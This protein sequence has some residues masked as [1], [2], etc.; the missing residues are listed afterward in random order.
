MMNRLGQRI[1]ALLSSFYLSS[2]RR[3]SLFRDR[4]YPERSEGS[5]RPGTALTRDPSA[6]AGRR[7]SELGLQVGGTMTAKRL[8]FL[9]V[10]VP[11]ISCHPRPT[12]DLVLA[13]VALKA[14]QKVKADSLAP[15]LY[16]KAEN[17][18]LRAKKD[19]ADG[20]YDSCRK[21]SNEARMLAEQA[22]YKSLQKQ[23][24]L[25]D[26]PADDEGVAPPPPPGA[27]PG[28]E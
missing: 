18:Y 25:R 17:N 3:D 19:Y 24:Q 15:D 13:D 11:L 8:L 22:E 12:E 4:I 2:F 1:D 20:Y 14:A 5:R 9:L 28:T 27:A 21:Y 16:R 7:A 26:K 10:L 6:N 23:T